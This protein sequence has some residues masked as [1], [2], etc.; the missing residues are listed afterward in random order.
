MS[1][2]QSLL[3]IRMDNLDH[4]MRARLFLSKIY[5]KKRENCEKKIM[6]NMVE[7]GREILRCAFENFPI[8]M[9]TDETNMRLYYNIKKQY[10]INK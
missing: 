5:S 8:S 6:C 3:D 2:F 9:F 1:E 7:G 10:N 4:Q